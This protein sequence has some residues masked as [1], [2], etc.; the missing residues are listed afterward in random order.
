[1]SILVVLT[2]SAILAAV[3]I[4][5]SARAEARRQESRQKTRLHCSSIRFAE[6]R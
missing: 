2:M 5:T 1:M 6:G 3:Y 4:Y